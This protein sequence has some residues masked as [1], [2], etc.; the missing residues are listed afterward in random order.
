MKWKLNI[1]AFIWDAD[2]WCRIKIGGSKE[3]NLKMSW[4]NP[5]PQPRLTNYQKSPPLLGLIDKQSGKLVW[6]SK[7]IQPSNIIDY[8]LCSDSKVYLYHVDSKLKQIA[9]RL[10]SC[11]REI[12]A[13]SNPCRIESQV[14]S[15]PIWNPLSLANW[16]WEW[17]DIT[18]RAFLHKPPCKTCKKEQASIELQ[19]YLWKPRLN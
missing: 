14:P 10:C 11:S 8:T 4:F 13:C 15:L 7:L 18:L 9:L 1:T 17:D 5:P 19:E 16:D 12:F 3:R 6:N 2:C